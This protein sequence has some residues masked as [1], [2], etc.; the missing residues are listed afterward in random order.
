VRDL[1]E[2]TEMVDQVATVE[3]DRY[4]QLVV[5]HDAL[6]TALA[7]TDGDAQAAGR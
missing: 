1:E 6:R 3:G 5:A 2:L 7:E 4:E